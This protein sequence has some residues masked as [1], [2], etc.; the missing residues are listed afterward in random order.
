MT[1]KNILVIDDDQ[2]MLISLSAILEGNGFDVCTAQSGKDGISTFRKESPDL[3][4][5]DMM[6]ENID[7]GVKVVNQLRNDNKNVPIFL[8]S[9]SAIELE[10][11]YDL[12]ELGF[13]GVFQ[14][15][16]PMDKLISSIKK[17]LE[18]SKD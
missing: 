18:V 1:N 2:D 14:K 9:S 8:I 6:M 11:K 13:N 5:C 17:S 10:S 16:L 3:V 7:E 4:L 12:D 15:P